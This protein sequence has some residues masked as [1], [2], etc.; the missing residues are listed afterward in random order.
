MKKTALFFL[1]LCFIGCAKKVIEKPDNLIPKDQMVL[2]LYDL[3]ILN[4]AKSSFRTKLGGSKIETMNFL[5]RKYDMDSVQFSQSDR[6]YA[7]IPLEYQDIYEKVDALLEQKKNFLEEENTRRTDSIR[8]ANE[9]FQDSTK[10]KE[11]DI[12]DINSGS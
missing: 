11:P 1:L 3:A 8:K 10:I 4:A 2:I 5:Y 6:Y 9:S 12:K 7:S